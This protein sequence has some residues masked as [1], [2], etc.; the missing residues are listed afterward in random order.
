MP[1]LSTHREAIN[2]A[3]TTA[4]QAADSLLANCF[5]RAQIDIRS[6]RHCLQYALDLVS[7]RLAVPNH[8]SPA[9][10]FFGSS[11]EV[12]PETREAVKHLAS[13]AARLGLSVGTGGGPGICLMLIRV[14]MK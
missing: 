9:I 10:T 13:E 8:L 1:K 11:R 6:L 7:L 3:A 14:H 4:G 2:Y 12:A 5:P